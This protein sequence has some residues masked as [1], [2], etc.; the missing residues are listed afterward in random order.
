M[1]RATVI[2]QDRFGRR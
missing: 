1:D 2:E